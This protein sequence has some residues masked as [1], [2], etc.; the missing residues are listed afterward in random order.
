[1]SPW[2][3]FLQMILRK[4]GESVKKKKMKARCTPSPLYQTQSK[5]ENDKG[6]KEQKDQS[7]LKIKVNISR[8][9]NIEQ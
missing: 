2:I 4:K 5:K 8:D 6:G 9:Q 3:L 1:M 7:G